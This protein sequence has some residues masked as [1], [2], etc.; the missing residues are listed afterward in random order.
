MFCPNCGKSEQ[1]KNSFCRQCGTFLPDFDKIKKREI[2]PEEHLK[3]NSVL[4]FMTAIVSITLAIL[5]YSFFLGGENTH[6]VI[7][8]TA[9]FLT[10]MFFWQA[11]VFWRTL[12]LKKQFPKRN[13]A[14]IEPEISKV[15]IDAKTKELLNEA[16]FSDVVPA[17]V[18]EKTTKNLKQKIGKSS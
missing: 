16:D 7:Y 15:S 9:G 2:S 5:L 12:Q 13:N 11:Q 1:E 14:D 18:T 10:A 17:S 6:P 8:I 3:V 4:N